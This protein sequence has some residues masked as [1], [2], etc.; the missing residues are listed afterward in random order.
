MDTKGKRPLRELGDDDD[1][2]P[3]SNKRKKVHFD[4]VTEVRKFSGESEEPDDAEEED[5]E[6]APKRRKA[7]RL[8]GYDSD[9][10]TPALA[11]GMG[12]DDDDLFGDDT[13]SSKKAKRKFESKSKKEVKFMQKEDIEGQEWENGEDDDEYDEGG[14]KIEPFN[15]DD[16]LQNGAFDESG[17]Y[18]RKK[19]EFEHHDKWLQGT[20]RDD[21]EKVGVGFAGLG[22]VAALI[23]IFLQARLAHEKQVAQASEQ[24]A[25]D[26]KAM[27][28]LD[29]TDLWKVL[30]MLLKPGENIIRALKRLG[31][32]VPSS[33]VP[34]WKR[35][36][37]ESKR[38]KEQMAVL[39][40]KTHKQAQSLRDDSHEIE[41]RASAKID[42]DAITALADKMMAMGVLDVYEE[43]FEQITRQ[44]RLKDVVDEFWQPGEGRPAKR[45]AL[46]NHPDREPDDPGLTARFQLIADAY[47]TL[48][49]IGKRRDYDSRHQAP[50]SHVNANGLFTEVFE[51]LLR[52]EV[53]GRVRQTSRGT[54]TTVGGVS[55]AGIGF[56][57]ANVPGAI[58]GGVVGGALGMIRDRKGM[59][60]LD[61]FNQL[62]TETRQEII[63]VIS[64]I[65]MGGVAGYAREKLGLTFGG[66]TP[67]DVLLHIGSKNP[68]AGVD[69]APINSV[70]VSDSQLPSM[71]YSAPVVQRKE[72][73]PE[74]PG[75]RRVVFT[76]PETVRNGDDT[77]GNEPE[78]IN[79]SNWERRLSIA[80]TENGTSR[81]G[82]TGRG[83][84][85]N[86]GEER[87]TFVT[88]RAGTLIELPRPSATI[89]SHLAMELVRAQHPS[90][91]EGRRTLQS[92]LL[93]AKKREML[94]VQQ[95]LDEKRAEFNHRMQDC[96]EKQEELMAKQK[97][98]R[99]RVSKFE[100]FLVENDAKRQRALVKAQQE[101]KT[102]ELKD[103]ELAQLKERLLQESKSAEQIRKLLEKYRPYE[104]YLQLVVSTLPLNYLDTPEPQISDFLARHRTLLET[105]LDLERQLSR[106]Q[107]E[108]EREQTRLSYLLKEKSDTILVYNST[109]GTLQKRLDAMKGENASV[110]A[111]VN[112][113]D[114]AAKHKVRLCGPPMTSQ[115]NINGKRRKVALPVAPRARTA[116]TGA[117]TDDSLKALL[118]KLTAIRDRL[119]DLQI[120]VKTLEEESSSDVE[121]S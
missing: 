90:I 91:F 61:S 36:L 63:K 33:T 118:E 99:E 38:K 15:M 17:M 109:L 74:S 75:G 67:P 102:R 16:E 8:E 6:L 5:L 18:I 116:P 35:K 3:N 117:S 70:P 22:M 108:I 93:L 30:L 86:G 13:K 56:I 89:N 97:Q 20:T 64:G 53:D 10:D 29:I 11:A 78:G 57:V 27:S 32:N 7:V 62:P 65:I 121:P 2:G 59:S 39:A 104:E 66:S 82:D 84:S 73:R 72:L 94:E 46:L 85:E 43:T 4:E 44:L 12:D 100:K 25:K 48:S 105:S 71:Y 107:D 79:N 112:D 80:K 96:R 23:S 98:I 19:D 101:R 76:E 120:I 110:E 31:S 69:L 81:E 47:Y 28:S 106:S 45:L 58:V 77:P 87:D 1:H 41:A 51:D 114:R 92:T 40:N 49:D 37:E 26:R 83:G 24:D 50:S 103:V 9:D 119:I 14:V 42:M 88:Q 34:A 21:I 115:G 95:Q 52:P 60:L 111:K 55:G 54:F 68:S 113:R